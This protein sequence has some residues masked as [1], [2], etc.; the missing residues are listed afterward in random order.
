MLNTGQATADCFG[1]VMGSCEFEQVKCAIDIRFRIEFWL[2]QRRPNTGA[3]R[4][5]H[6]HVKFVF[7]EQGR[8]RHCVAN[9]GVNE[10]VIRRSQM[11]GNIG[12][13]YLRRVKIVKIVNDSYLPAALAEQTI[14]KM[15]ANKSGTTC[16][17]YVSFM[18]KT[19]IPHF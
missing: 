6:D 17:E 5:V 16:Y 2:A 8:H 19:R 12:V 10:P 13:F 4:Q 14:N 18:H 11:F 3:R 15:R 1:G 9:V 7:P